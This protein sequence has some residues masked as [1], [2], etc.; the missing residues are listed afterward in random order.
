MSWLWVL[1][2]RGMNG[3][4]GLHTLII[5]SSQLSASITQNNLN[6]RNKITKNCVT[7]APH[8][9]LSYM[10][11]FSKSDTEYLKW[12][13]TGASTLVDTQ[14][15]GA[16]GPTCRDILDKRKMKFIGL[17]IYISIMTN[18]CQVFHDMTLRVSGHLSQRHR[19]AHFILAYTMMWGFMWAL[20]CNWPLKF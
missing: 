11:N 16:C 15:P 13:V 20:L 3:Y 12:A 4:G 2:W 1:M 8:F 9:Y 17:P 14:R 6:S 18:G 10:V 5:W 19:Y 7:S